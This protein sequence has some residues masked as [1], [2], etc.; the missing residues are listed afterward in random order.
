MNLHLSAPTPAFHRHEPA[1]SATDQNIQH[2]LG[3][4]LD[5]GQYAQPV[6]DDSLD[7]GCWLGVAPNR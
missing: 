3:I 1:L 6:T 7:A 2:R 4:S 5:F